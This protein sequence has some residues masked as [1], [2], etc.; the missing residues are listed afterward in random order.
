MFLQYLQHVRHRET[1]ESRNIV[2]VGLADVLLWR[3]NNSHVH[4]HTRFKRDECLENGCVRREQDCLK[5][6]VGD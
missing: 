4:T 2:R 6:L 3:R 5:S 1:V